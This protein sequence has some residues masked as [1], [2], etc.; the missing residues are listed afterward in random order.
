[1]KLVLKDFQER[2]VDGLLRQLQL[3][4]SEVDVAGQPQSLALSSPTGSGK[5]VIMTALVEYLIEGTDSE[6]GDPNATFLWIT[7]QP[8]LNEQTRNK[9][10]E[11]SSRL[12][13]GGLEVVDSGFDQETFDPSKIYFLNTQKLGKEKNLIT[14]GDG[15]S[16]TL[17]ETI[18]NTVRARPSSFYVILDEA[19]RGMRESGGSGSQAE[20]IV[21][22]FIKGSGGEIP[23]I[24]LVV[25]M[26][27]TP[28]RFQKLVAG[29]GR[30]TR[31]YDV[32]PEDVRESGLLKQT[33]TLW[34]PTES[35]PGDMTMLRQAASDLRMF[36]EEW[37]TYCKE[38]DEPVVR[39]ILLVQVEDGSARRLSKTPI[40]QA[41]DAINDAIGPFDSR[42]FA[43]A[44]EEHSV[45]SVDGHDLRYLAPASIDTDLDVRVVF[46]KTALNT[47]WDCPRAEVMMS[48]RRAKDVTLIAQL[49]GRMVRTPLARPVGTRPFLNNV[50]LYL[51]HYDSDGLDKV[52][53]H[54]TSPDRDTA[55]PADVDR[56][57][58][59]VAVCLDP[60][61]AFCVAALS[62]VPSYTIPRAN[63]TS[64]LRRMM[65]LA[66]Q[67]SNTGILT[68]AP[69]QA[70]SL[71]TDRLIK[72][73][74][75]L[76][77]DPKFEELKAERAQLEISGRQHNLEDQSDSK[78]AHKLNVSAE[79]IR[80][81]FEVAGRRLG[82]GVHRDFLQVRCL[83]DKVEVRTA[84]LEFVA[85]MHAEFD[86][87]ASIE[88]LAQARV[89]EWSTEHR[90]AISALDDGD[91]QR[92]EAVL[93]MGGKPI[94][95]KLDSLPEQLLERTQENYWQ[96]HLYID[97]E[98]LFPQ[99]LNT[100][101][102]A[103]LEAEIGSEDEDGNLSGGRSDVVGWLR[104]PPRKDHSFCIP[105][106]QAGE[107]K[108]VY[109]D[110]LL[111][112]EEG[113]QVVVDIIDPHA[114]SLGDA[115]DK[116]RGLAQYAR[117]HGL[118]VGRIELVSLKR[119]DIRR[120]DLKNEKTRESVLAISSS[121]QLAKLFD[122]AS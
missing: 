42:A 101:E 9:M 88:S 6:V 87:R 47:G 119:G 56:G 40:A 90:G 97:G 69:E 48:F 94:Q 106:S 34:H 110:F 109:P 105:Y 111:F 67:L 14:H 80:D 10:T 1:V 86:E 43:H 24:P 112:R 114:E 55:L 31:S 12:W 72:R 29:T 27:A 58:Q 32:S 93:K 65:R 62:K 53:E 103:T 13:M 102:R 19:H 75:E 81:L 7:D 71:V 68:A 41:I 61:L 44:F 26:S 23:P 84:R 100:W 64:E 115:A 120:L 107:V 11:Y 91:R 99:K 116:A 96:R 20:S 104:N 50:N 51:P 45:V 25:G 59:R 39:P 89:Q 35:Q 95:G 16:F 113:D 38:E 57:S 121:A 82:E 21:Q 5:T 70:R 46:F 33:I 117:D 118:D 92:F 78:Q 37:K 122:E 85:L 83:T 36:S 108:P 52:V 63:R 28:E 74:G 2:A 60:D 17:W 8:E 49:V 76:T 66:R 30:T 79:N 4:R 22:K 77:G 73:V 18:A 54:L 98:G 15:R 3:A